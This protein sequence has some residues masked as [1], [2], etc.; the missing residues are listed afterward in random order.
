MIHA[1]YIYLIIGAAFGST[2]VFGDDFLRPDHEEAD[3]VAWALCIVLVAII[4]GTWPVW[5]YYA[6][7]MRH[8]M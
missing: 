4:A 7:R 3:A 1:I 6:W 8:T 5:F 2:F